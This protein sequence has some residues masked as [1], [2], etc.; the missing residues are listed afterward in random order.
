MK[1]KCSNIKVRSIVENKIPIV[2]WLPKYKLSS[3]F[4][5]FVAGLT[6]GLTLIPQA[7]AY[8]A[9]AGL[10]PQ[11]GL[12]SGLAGTFVYIFFGTVKQ[13]NIGPTAV[14][15]LLTYNYTRGTN[16]DFAVLL[17]F[18]SGVVE[19]LSGLFNLGCLVEFVSV[20]VTAGFSSAA[21][22]VIACSQIKGLLGISIN[23]ENFIQ[24]WSE[25]FQHVADTRPWDLTLSIGCCVILLSLRKLKD[26]RIGFCASAKLNTVTNHVL[27]LLSTAR[28]ALVV[29][30]CAGMA[31]FLTR[32]HE[33]PFLLTGAIQAGFPNVDFP[34]FSTTVGNKT[35]TFVEMCSYLGKGIVVVPLVSLLNNVAIAKAFASEG[36]FDGSQE[37]MTLGLCNVVASF[38]RSMPV[39]GSFSRSA[40]NNA[41][42]VKTPMGNL[43]T[44][45]LVVLALGFLTPYFYYIPKATLSS[46]IVCAVIFMVEFRLIGHIWRANKKDLIPAFAT[47]FACL[48]SGV[49]VGILFGLAID[50]IYLLYLNARPSCKVEGKLNLESPEYVKFCPK[51]SFLFPNIDYIRTKINKVIVD[52]SDVPLIIDC[53][54]VNVVDFSAIQGLRALIGDVKKKNRQIIFYKLKESIVKRLSEVIGD[55]FVHV[56][57]DLGQLSKDFFENSKLS[58]PFDSDPSHLNISMEKLKLSSKTDV[59]AINR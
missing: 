18:L 17:C 39:S 31:Y 38:F 44:G 23:S 26:V 37:M 9:L 34:P 57:T 59:E 15:S 8:A 6:V 25:V 11:Y 41:S 54:H 36:I 48:W 42:G 12:Y 14:V 33:T 3:L 47:F 53:S 27:W 49:E 58:L 32:G 28:N 19:L 21:A 51:T 30:A 16:S 24:T 13:V 40:V 50:L 46:V 43:Y 2:T 55:D 5:D 22:L 20:P 45:C 35:Y 29:I 1:I 56:S 7:I 4:A 52:T 10:E